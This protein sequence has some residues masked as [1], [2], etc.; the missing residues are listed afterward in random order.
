M[1]AACAL[2][3]LQPCTAQPPSP[4]SPRE[5]ALL[6]AAC[7]TCHGP[8][9]RGAASI[10]GQRG[11]GSTFLLERMQAFQAGQVGGATVMPLLMQGYDATQMQALAQWFARPQGGNP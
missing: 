4:P 9:G 5:T 2:L 10:P 3:W 6:A 11:R 8:G 7:V 1:L